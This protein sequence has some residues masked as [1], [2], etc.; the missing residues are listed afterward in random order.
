MLDYGYRDHKTCS[1]EC[2]DIYFKGEHAPNWKGGVSSDHHNFY[3]GAAYSKW[4]SLIFERDNF[5]CIECEKH[6]GNLNAHHILPYRDWKDEQYSL[7]IANG[8]TLCETCHKKTFGREYE[9]F[10][11]YFDIA[12]G[13]GV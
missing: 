11:K 13:V 4:R 2:Y 8:A 12:N 9:F 6:G 5:T 7:N 1:K 10:D 3:T